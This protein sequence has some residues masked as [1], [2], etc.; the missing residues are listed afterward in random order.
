MVKNK[1][2]LI[3]KKYAFVS[4]FDLIEWFVYFVALSW[5][6]LVYFQPKIEILVIVSLLIICVCIK[7]EKEYL[8]DFN[9]IFLYSIILTILSTILLNKEKIFNQGDY[10]M[11][12]IAIETFSKRSSINLYNQYLYDDGIG[13]WYHMDKIFYPNTSHFIVST[14]V[15]NFDLD[16]QMTFLLFLSITAFYLW[17]KN[18]YQT[19]KIINEKKN[20]STTNVTLMILTLNFFT[21]FS[22][23]F[24]GL[25]FLIGFV[26]AIFFF[27]VNILG[28]KINSL[29]LIKKLTI[30]LPLFLIHPSSLFIYII[31]VLIQFSN[32]TRLKKLSGAPLKYS[33]I[34]KLL[35]SILIFIIIL[36]Y[37]RNF[38]I[39]LTNSQ[40]APTFET[41]RISLENID[42]ILENL[43]KY[44]AS[45]HSIET[46]PLLLIIILIL[47]FKKILNFKNNENY[48]YLFASTFLMLFSFTVG[49]NIELLHNI[50]RFLTAGFNSHPSRIYGLFVFTFALF[51][52]KLDLGRI[53]FLR[54]SFINSFIWLCL[55]ISLNIISILEIIKTN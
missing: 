45:G 2:N 36:Y 53:K 52:S 30:A 44:F 38:I 5:I 12:F 50:G 37:G 10:K 19:I 26:M 39:N 20:Y 8:R 55:A 18:L 29:N 32:I 33:N 43:Y 31:L 28:R 42:R 34:N 54:T 48:K 41:N 40:S 7:K 23:F 3:A 47:K 22:F 11:H 46:L 25:P 24:G 13:Y 16:L 14:F 21:F 6:S 15:K 35:I 17:P 4:K 1:K 49:L 27:R 9:F 51:I